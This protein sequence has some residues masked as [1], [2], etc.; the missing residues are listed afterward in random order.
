MIELQINRLEDAAGLERALEDL[1]V[2]ADVQYLGTDL[3]CQDDRY[4]PSERS[5]PDDRTAYSFGED[6]ISVRLD[7]REVGRGDTL[8]IA[9][10]TISPEGD[11]GGGISDLGGV[12]GE[13][14][15]AHGPVAPCVPEPLPPG[16][17]D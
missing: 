4:E 16:P 12:Y 1:G 14:G 15:V 8:V 2:P 9:A 7:P 10:S 6:G 13:V 3:R 11:L 17:E 5:V